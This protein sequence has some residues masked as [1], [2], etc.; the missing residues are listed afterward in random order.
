MKIAVI[1]TA[2]IP[3]NYGGFETL[4]QN[5]AEYHQRHNLDVELVVYCSEKHHRERP[6]RFLNTHLRYLSMSANGVWS[7]PYDMW[8]IL[9]AMHDRSHV[10]LILG[11]SGTI[12]LPIL[13]ALSSVRIVTNIDG[14]EWRREKWRGLARWFLR[15]SES[16]AV[17]HSDVVIADNAVIATYVEAVY[18]VYPK[19]IAYGGDH[20]VKAGQTAVRL[21]ELP[22]DYAFSVCRIEP[23]NNIHLILKAFATYPHFPLVLVGNW[24]NSLYGRELKE[25]FH[26]Y[27][28]LF[29]LDSIYDPVKLHSLRSNALVYVHGHSAGGTNPSLV[30][31]M[32]FGKAVFAYDCEFNR[33][34]TENHGLFFKDESAL[35]DLINNWSSF[36]CASIGLK[37]KE[38]AKRR[39]TWEIVA[40]LYFEILESE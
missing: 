22:R 36:G 21:L 16:V 6:Q 37:M 1:G 24:S 11:V 34:T 5:L 7:I 15:V 35:C 2:G 20:A 19:V 14:I 38:I 28:H 8:S 27:Q 3:A 13:R 9:K 31:A 12:A 23:E 25:R 33:S 32:H 4:V 30:E 26:G 18:N 39:Y 10:L 17:R 29:L 40:K